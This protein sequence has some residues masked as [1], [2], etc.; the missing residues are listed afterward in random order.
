[1][2]TTESVQ[3]QTLQDGEEDPQTAAEM[4]LLEGCVHFCQGPLQRKRHNAH[5]KIN[6][7][8]Q[9]WFKVEPGERK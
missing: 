5:T 1:M 7:W 2:S 9:R 3:R 6:K 4:A 8:K